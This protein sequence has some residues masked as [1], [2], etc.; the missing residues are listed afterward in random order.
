MCHCV[1]L[2]FPL[3]GLREHNFIVLCAE[4]KYIFNWYHIVVGWMLILLRRK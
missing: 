2:N 3:P 4:T 1:F